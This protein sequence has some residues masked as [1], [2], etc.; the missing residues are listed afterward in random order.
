MLQKLLR[1]SAASLGALLLAACSG[2]AGEP[3]VVSTLVP[4]PTARPTVQPAAATAPIAI[5]LVQGER[6]FAENC[7]RCHGIGGA[8]DGELVQNGSISEIPDFTDPLSIA[9]RTPAEYFDVITNGRL[10]KL[11]PP[12]INSLSEAE[13][14]AVTMYSYSLAYTP[15]LLATGEQLFATQCLNCHGADGRGVNNVPALSALTN[16]NEA[17]LLALVTNG[18]GQM[19]AFNE[20]DAQALSAVSAYA[21]SLTWRGTAAVDIVDVPP[22]A[23]TEEAS[24]S[25]ALTPSAQ[26]PSDVIGSVSGRVVAGTAGMNLPLESDATLHIFDTQGGEQTLSATIDSGGA[27]AFADVPL[28][29]GQAY[30]VSVQTQEGMFVSDTSYAVPGISEMSMDVT[31]FETTSDVSVVSLEDMAFQIDAGEISVQVVQLMKFVNISDRIYV[32]PLGPG[33]PRHSLVFTLPEGATLSQ[34]G[35][36]LN[37]FSL[38]DDGRLLLDTWPLIPGE[39]HI[40]HLVYTWPLLEQGTLRQPFDYAY[41]GPGVEVFANADRIGIA[42]DGLTAESEMTFNNQ[43]YVSYRVPAP[44]SA[45]STLDFNITLRPPQAATTAGAPSSN[46][47]LAIVFIAAGIGSLG[48]AGV[49]YLRSN[50]HPQPA[51]A[52]PLDPREQTQ[53]LM[54]QIAALDEQYEAGKVSEAQYETKRAALKT[55]LARLMKTQAEAAPTPKKGSK[56][57][58]KKK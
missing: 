55:E 22:P 31:V 1:I 37:R 19:P 11:M 25:A 42:A 9:G 51:T 52:A 21:R 46:A 43:R 16:L 54:Q 53:T 15:E 58:G 12:W 39:E 29:H 56:K 23:S 45:G 3:A 24:A 17:D 20:L 34:S 7:T 36:D 13:R 8:G 32:Q 10:D 14:W 40:V 38:S 50:R 28:R 2:L 18:R 6:I 49:L 41:A 47:T 33:V 44:A 57:Q 30:I 35:T 5:D 27:Y 48:L 4:M 26:M